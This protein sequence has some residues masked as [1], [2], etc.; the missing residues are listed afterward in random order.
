MV[1]YPKMVPSTYATIRV[2]REVLNCRLPIEVWFRPDEMRKVTASIDPLH[3]LAAS[4]SIGGVTFREI[5]DPLAVEFAT[6]VHAI[7]HSAFDRVLFLDSDNVPVRDPSFLFETPEFVDTG[8]VF[9]PDFW[10][11]QHTMFYLGEDSLLWELLD[12]PFVDMFE[13]ESGQ[14]LIDRRRHAAAI[15]LLRFFTFHRP[16]PFVQLKLVWGDKDLFRLAWLKLGA[17]FHMIQHPPAIAG[18][19]INR[20]FCGMTMVQHD[21]QGAVLFLHRN[22]HKLTGGDIKSPANVKLRAIS[23]VTRTDHASREENEDKSSET[24]RDYPD[25][26][27]WTHLLSFRS[28]SPRSEYRIE[29]YHAEPEFPK[30]QMCYGQRHL[31]ANVNFYA[32]EFADMS[33]SGLETE[34]RRFAMEAGQLH[35]TKV[36]AIAE[37]QLQRRRQFRL[38]RAGGWS[39]WPRGMIMINENQP[40]CLLSHTI[41]RESTSM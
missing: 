14:L 2:L 4:D 15:E 3:Q 22:S 6:K 16:N 19:A 23:R 26:A 30:D 28:S 20:Y 21:A 10:H 17:P 25:A 8:A 1:V 7:Y 40:E 27:I 24:A 13:Q 29:T 9:W 31:D 11:P 36:N 32:Q 41:S 18:T 12:L 33:F 5:D 37:K 35:Q 39:G 34:L 38:Q